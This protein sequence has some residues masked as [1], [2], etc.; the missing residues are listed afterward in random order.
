MAED[1]AL[2]HGDDLAVVEVQVRAT[3]GAACGRRSVSEPAGWSTP[4]GERANRRSHAPVTLRMTSLSSV[5]S[6]IGA[7][8]TL[9]LLVPCQVRAFIVE[10]SARCLYSGVAAWSIGTGPPRTLSWRKLEAAC[11]RGCCCC[12][13]MRGG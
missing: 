3:D 11:M 12:W 8:T 7:S 2:L 6:G 13:K 10:P 5:I 4:R 9:T 1:V